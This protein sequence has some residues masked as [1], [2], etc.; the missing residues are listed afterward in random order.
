[1]T[2]WY[3]TFPQ[4]WAYWRAYFGLTDVQA[5]ERWIWSQRYG[6]GVLK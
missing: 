2:Y 1:V 4:L 6:I 3:H 5:M